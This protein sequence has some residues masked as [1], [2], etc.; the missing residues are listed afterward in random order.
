MQEIV[1]RNISRTFATFTSATISASKKLFLVPTE[2]CTYILDLISFMRFWYSNINKKL[3][4]HPIDSSTSHPKQLRKV[5][6]KI[7]DRF[8]LKNLKKLIGFLSKKESCSVHNAGY[9]NFSQKTLK[10]ILTKYSFW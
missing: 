6:F 10:I 9:T 3:K 1:A 5:L 2:I 4:I 7:S 8:N